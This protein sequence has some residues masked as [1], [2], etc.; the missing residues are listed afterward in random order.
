MPARTVR[1]I[2]GVDFSGADR[3][4]NS[5][6]IACGEVNDTQLHIQAVKSAEALF[7]VGSGRERC[8]SALVGLI[9]GSESSIFGLDFP[10]GIPEEIFNKLFIKAISTWRD[11]AIEFVRHFP[12]PDKFQMM[13]FQAAGCHERK[14]E[15]D[16]SAGAPLCPYNLRL[17]K[18]TYFGIADVLAPLVRSDSAS[19]LPMEEP[20]PE[21]PWV[22]EICPS[23]TLRAK[24]LPVS[25]YKGPSG[26]HR[27]KRAEILDKLLDT[28][29]LRLSGDE[30]RRAVI[31]DSKGD[32]L[33]SVVAALAALQA[34]QEI[35][36][37]RLEGAAA[38]E[39]HIYV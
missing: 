12:N 34:L 5:I 13:C 24:E 36:T 23:S 30:I 9:C 22:V 38:I 27:S 37:G 29:N 7:G 26:S 11:F 18:Q 10:F 15:T 14:R 17:Y 2:Y 39:G 16:K 20:D 32:A 21:K 28:A 33:D 8:L 35:S 3:A 31:E 6:W 19:V 4:G 1:K 25:G